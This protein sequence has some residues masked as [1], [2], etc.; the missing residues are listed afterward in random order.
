MGLSIC[1][2]AVTD[3]SRIWID[4]AWEELFYLFTIF[5]CITLKVCMAIDRV[6][7]SI[8]WDLT[9]KGGEHL[10]LLLSFA[11]IADDTLQIR[12]TGILETEFQM[13][14]LWATTSRDPSWSPLPLTR[15]SR[16]TTST[17][18]FPTWVKMGTKIPQQAIQL[19]LQMT[20]A[21]LM[22]WLP[23]IEESDCCP[24]CPHFIVLHA[25]LIFE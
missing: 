25:V 10:H 22:Q 3:P 7:K 24:S 2:P 14:G 13:Y 12:L 9:F 21:S 5:W 23:V 8:F 20:K 6:T 4:R 19:P 1:C 15:T 11:E 18:S 16:A 17:T